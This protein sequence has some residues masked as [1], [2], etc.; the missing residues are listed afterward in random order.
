MDDFK[1][2]YGLTNSEIAEGLDELSD[3]DFYE[4]IVELAKRN[5]ETANSFP[6][7]LKQVLSEIES[8]IED[9]SKL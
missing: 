4:V 2:K 6:E 3:T 7:W 8:N 9:Q 1:S 5:N